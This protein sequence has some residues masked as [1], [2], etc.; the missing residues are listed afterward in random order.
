MSISRVCEWNHIE[1]LV[2]FLCRFAS[3]LVPPLRTRLQ[4]P[5]KSQLQITGYK[6]QVTGTGTGTGRDSGFFIAGT[7]RHD[8]L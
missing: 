8:V 6:L 5:S 7:Q 2:C 4:I 3:L 1:V